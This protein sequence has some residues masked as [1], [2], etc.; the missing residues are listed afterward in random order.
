MPP[1]A[2]P[3]R[4]PAHSIEIEKRKLNTKQ[5]RRFFVPVQGEQERRFH[6]CVSIFPPMRKTAIRTEKCNADSG[7]F[8]ES[9]PEIVYNIRIKDHE[10]GRI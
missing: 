1:V 4:P 2:L 7:I 6:F 9:L 3:V 10:G 8:M 5:K